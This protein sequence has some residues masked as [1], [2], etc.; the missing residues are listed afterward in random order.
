[1]NSILVSAMGGVDALLCVLAA[2]AACDYLRKVRPVDQPLLCTAF[3]L[4]AIGAFG[5]FVTAI[6]GHWVNPFGVMLHAGVVA[7]AWSRRGHVFG[8]ASQSSG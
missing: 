7:Y 3:Y 4:V 1:M 6:Q 8:A 2:L 5:A